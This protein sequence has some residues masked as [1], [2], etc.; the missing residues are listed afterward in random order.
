[1]SKPEIIKAIDAALSDRQLMRGNEAF[2]IKLAADLERYEARGGRLD[3]ASIARV[4][5]WY[6]FC[7]EH[8]INRLELATG[9][10][11]RIQA[12]RAEKQAE[13]APLGGDQPELWAV[14]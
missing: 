14:S 1:M 5:G 9:I 4:M 3:S 2:A 6:G 11:T 13:T 12:A 7:Y 10:L 8:R